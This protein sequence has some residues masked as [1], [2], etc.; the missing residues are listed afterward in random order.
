MVV[1]HCAIRLS[2]LGHKIRIIVA[3][4]F[5]VFMKLIIL[6]GHIFFSEYQNYVTI[7]V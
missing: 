2:I 7:H 6:T 3:L 5:Y 4:E 1:S